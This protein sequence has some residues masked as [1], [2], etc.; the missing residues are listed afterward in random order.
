MQQTHPS[1]DIW[2]SWALSRAF[3]LFDIR[4]C[5]VWLNLVEVDFQKYRQEEW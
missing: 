1:H 3:D 4:H 2:F 5:F